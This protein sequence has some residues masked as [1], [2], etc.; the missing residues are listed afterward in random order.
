[1]GSKFCVGAD[2]QFHKKK[3][4]GYN[5]TEKSDAFKRRLPHQSSK[6]VCLGSSS[7]WELFFGCAGVAKKCKRKNRKV[8]FSLSKRAKCVQR[9]L[10]KKHG[11]FVRLDAKA[12]IKY[13]KREN[14]TSRELPARFICF[15]LRMVGPQLIE[16]RPEFRKIFRTNHNLRII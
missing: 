11:R 7:G 8:V 5:R 3:N 6:G 9:W 12:L 10:C 4:I 2:F 15:L 1:M 16:E 13:A 14:K